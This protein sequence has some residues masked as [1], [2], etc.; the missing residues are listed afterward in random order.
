MR[1]K[2]SSRIFTVLATVI[3][4]LIALNTASAQE[5][6]IYKS[7]GSEGTIVGTITFVGVPPE[8]F[9]IDTSADS[10]C[11]R[12]SRKLFT[13]W[14][15]VTNQKLA[16]VVVYL[17]G[18][19][20]DLY[21][22]AAPSSDVTLEH[23]GCRYLPHVLGLQTQQSLRVLNSDPTVHNTHVVAK[24]NREWNQSQPP[25]GS[26]LEERFV[27]PETFLRIKDNQHP[28]ENAYVGVFSHPFFSV[29]GLDGTYKISGVP[30]GHYTLVA[31]QEK[32]GE[33][34]VDLFVA[35]NEQ[36]RVDFTFKPSNH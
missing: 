24:N 31:W 12:I 10:V 3:L 9:R 27:L 34:T 18:G 15:V 2:N 13:D 14:V 1:S 25:G 35:G 11:T 7:T 20:L 16:N 4:M 19:S 23:R 32:L 33:Q 5:K 22:F 30:P 26:P 28:W 17:R 29:S 8:P 36:K 21:S 6:P